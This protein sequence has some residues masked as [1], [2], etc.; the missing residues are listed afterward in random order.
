MALTDQMAAYSDCYQHFDRAQDTE[1][2]IRILVETQNQAHIMRMRLCHARVLERREAT[3]MFER[4]DPRH[5]KSIND[6][7][8]ITMRPTAE[9]DGKWWIYIEPWELAA[10]EVEV[11]EL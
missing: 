10:G 5:G 4:S 9:A 11:E 6:K 7:Y 8:R 1:K 2:G 3:R